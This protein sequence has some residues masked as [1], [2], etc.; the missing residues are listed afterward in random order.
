MVLAAIFS[1]HLKGTR[2]Y[3][4][5]STYIYTLHSH[6]NFMKQ[7]HLLLQFTDEETESKKA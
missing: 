6:N 2:D 3:L 1:A 4:K 5:C 7:V